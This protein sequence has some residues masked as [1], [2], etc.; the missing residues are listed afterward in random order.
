MPKGE[1]Y[2]N[3]K[4]AYDAWGIGLDDT[5]LT[6]LLTP[7]AAKSLPENSSRLRDGKTFVEGLPRKVA[8]R[9][10]VLPIHLTAPNEEAFFT[11]YASFCEELSKGK[12][13]ISTKYQPSVTYRCEYL[14]CS[15]FTQFMRGIAW[16]SLKLNEPDPTNRK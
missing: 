12:L 11:R 16:F 6:A 15:Q 13:E 8:E 3:G 4:D 5:A 14:S 2:I 9:D 1:L 7:P 10:L